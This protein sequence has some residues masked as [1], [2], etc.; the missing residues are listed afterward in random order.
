[1]RRWLSAVLVAGGLT[2]FV[3][4]PGL[5]A[6]ANLSG[7]W[8]GWAYF[9]G[10]NGDAPVRLSIRREDWGYTVRFDE[11]VRR[12]Y[13]LPATLLEW[14][15]PHV[16]IERKR[17]N[18][19]LI[20]LEGN[21][22]GD[23]VAGSVNWVGISG[24]F[25]LIRSAERFSRL[26]PEAF[27]DL[28]GSY[29]LATD[30]TLVVTARRWGEL[31][32]TDLGTGHQGTL[33]PV[34]KDSF[35]V[36]PAMYVPGP[37]QARVAF[38][39]DEKNSVRSVE[40]TAASGEKLSGR[41]IEIREEEVRFGEAPQVLVGTLLQPAGA[42]PL[43][44]AVVLGGS[45]WADRST[46]RRDAEILASFGMA[47][48]I[49]DRRGHGGS[50][51]SKV[52]S[53]EDD[54][55]DALAAA[56]F[57]RARPNILPNAIGVTG[58]SQG[59]WIAP[60]AASQSADVRFLVLFVPP[61]I[62]PVEQETTRRLNELA[63]QGFGKKAQEQEKAYFEL[64]VQYSQTRSNWPQYVAA[65]E[66]AKAAGFPEDVLAPDKPDDPD[67]EWGRL[68]WRYDPI[69]ILERVH[70]P[71]IALF[72]GADRNV[73]PNQNMSRMRAALLRAGN[74]DFRL[75]EVPGANHG[76]VSPPAGTSSLPHHRQIGIGNQGWPEVSAWLHAHLKLAGE[77]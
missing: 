12:E 27:A 69:P 57:L 44:A 15:E 37:V 53:F 43:P 50:T 38:H 52:H 17:P 11:L 64:A 4:E 35:L 7:D 18:G 1:M 58:R 2:C 62:T 75:I 30:R 46:C 36:G 60:L 55:R 40:W 73:V 13:D 59:G 6:E 26:R 14:R 28:T 29:H 70:C 39:R 10:T 33:F 22:S 54:A 24:R 71:V 32:Y 5:A 21:L 51:G 19:Q 63:D 9:D 47:T 67:W 16:V 3:V 8:A 42:G 76:L 23:I 31:L 45:G 68:N 20:R 41:R 61:A 66:R 77:N 34:D 49:F 65:Y 56:R 25:E 72:G 74:T 48:L